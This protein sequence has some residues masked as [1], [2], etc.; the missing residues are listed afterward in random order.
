MSERVWSDSDDWIDTLLAPLA[1]GGSIVLV[2]NADAAK[3]ATR[4]Q[5]EQVTVII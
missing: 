1:V 2:A 4:T 3:R 5:Q